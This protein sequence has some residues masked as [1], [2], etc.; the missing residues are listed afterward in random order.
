M[1]DYV[2][3]EFGA[4]YPDSVCIG[5]RLYDADSDECRRG[6][7][8][9]CPRCNTATMLADARETRWPAEPGHR[10]G[11]RSKTVL[12]DDGLGGGLRGGP[13]REPDDA[14]RVL[15]SYGRLMLDDWLDRDAVYAGL[16]PWTR[17]C[18]GHGRSIIPNE[19]D[20]PQG[21]PKSRTAGDAKKARR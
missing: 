7:D 16:A 15:T 4:C 8:L 9:A 19:T 10:V 12:R 13:G 11:K 2:G 18:P 20:E 21:R 17:P 3:H 6:G 5:G 1:C 14:A